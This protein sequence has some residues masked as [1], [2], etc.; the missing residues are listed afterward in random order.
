MHGTTVYRIEPRESTTCVSGDATNFVCPQG[1]WDL[2]S[3]RVQF[4]ATVTGKADSCSLPRN[5]AS[6]VD[7]IAVY[8]DDVEVQRIS[9]YNQIARILADYSRTD[10]NSDLLDHGEYISDTLAS[11]VYNAKDLPCCISSFHGLLGTDAVI[12]GAIRVQIFWAPDLVLIR[13]SAAGVYE[14][15]GLHAVIKQGD[16]ARITKTVVF[17]H[18]ASDSQRNQTFNQQTHISVHSNDIEY[19]IA[20]FLAIDYDHAVSTKGYGGS[21][22]YFAHGTTDPN[23]DFGISVQMSVDNIALCA[24]AIKYDFATGYMSDIFHDG[25]SIQ[26]PTVI[27]RDGAVAVRSIQEVLASQWCVGLP[28]GLKGVEKTVVVSFETVAAKAMP[29]HSL[30]YV[31]TNRVLE[32]DDDG[33]YMLTV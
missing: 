30:M 31:K 8:V 3:F 6:L 33:N 11:N 4:T 7:A 15:S 9:R 13:D 20:T 18:W 23:T 1:V 24:G 25:R 5:M 27:A 10:A 16:P 29:N 12:R 2:S 28:I 32:A 21:S 22:L 26:Y 19:V 17:D 14:L